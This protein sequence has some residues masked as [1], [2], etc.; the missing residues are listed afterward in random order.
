[1]PGLENMK[2]RTGFLGLFR[3]GG[4]SLLWA[5]TL[6]SQLGDQLVEDVEVHERAVL[7]R[8]ARLPTRRFQLSA[9]R[10][11]VHIRLL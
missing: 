9:S 7:E 11:V 6:T 3:N 1:M 8:R 10:R 5:G 2:A 4:F